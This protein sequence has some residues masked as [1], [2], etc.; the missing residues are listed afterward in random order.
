MTTEEQERLIEIL[1]WQYFNAKDEKILASTQFWEAIKNICLIYGVDH[2]SI[3]KA[4]RV[5]SAQENVPTNEEMYFLLNKLGLSVRQIKR[6]SGIYWQQQVEIREEHLIH[7]PV[8]KRRISDVVIK[9]NMK[10]FLHAIY[11]TLG[12]F[13]CIPLSDLS[14]LFE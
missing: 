8:I 10:H 2:I 11:D 3:S 13:N 1:V 14:E 9:F 6:F 12:V 4:A 7:P 5:L